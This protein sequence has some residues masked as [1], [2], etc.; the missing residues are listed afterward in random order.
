MTRRWATWEAAYLYYLDK[1]F[2]VRKKQAKEV[3]QMLDRAYAQLKADRYL[4]RQE[5]I[6]RRRKN[7]E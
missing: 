2:P 7:A 3:A 4:E 5:Q 6:A 1:G